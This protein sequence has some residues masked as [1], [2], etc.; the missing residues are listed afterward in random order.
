MPPLGQ[1]NDDACGLRWAVPFSVFLLLLNRGDMSSDLDQLRRG[2][3][4]RLFVR[5][6]IR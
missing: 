3:F 1:W 4:G 5:D 6:G 2:E